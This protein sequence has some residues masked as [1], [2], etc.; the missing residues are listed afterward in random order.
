MAKGSTA[1]LVTLTGMGVLAIGT[2]RS[3]M[4]DEKLPTFRFFAATA[5]T[6]TLLATVATVDETVGKGLSL[7]VITVVAIEGLPELL[8]RLDQQGDELG[9]PT[10]DGSSRIEKINTSKSKAKVQTKA[11]SNKAKVKGK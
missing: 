4:V 7:L 9:T 2:G 1:A 10:A 5:V 6:T 3:I 11:R 8:T